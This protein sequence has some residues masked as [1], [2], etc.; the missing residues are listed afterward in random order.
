MIDVGITATLRPEILEQTLVSFR[1]NL[2]SSVDP[3]KVRFII[4]ID[5]VGLDVS[6]DEMVD[7]IREVLK[8]YSTFCLLPERASFSQAFYQLWLYGLGDPIRYPYYF[9][10]ED[11]WQL[12]YRIDLHYLIEIMEVNSRLASLRLPMF[13]SNETMKNWNL[14]FPWNGTYYECPE[15]LKAAVGFCGHP[16]LIRKTFMKNLFPYLDKD[17]NPEKQFH[18]KGG[19]FEKEA[20]EW[21]Y[22]VFGRP[23]MG[24]YIK[25]LGRQ[26]MVDNNF[27]KKGT[28]AFFTHW[29]KKEASD[30]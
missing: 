17:K 29:T 22:G 24:P 1:D 2:F 3:N 26:W 30:E 11:D 9:N 25:D 27:R 8:G 7:M 21:E 20:V 18:Q 14:H 15:N 10:L 23:G 6:Q 5:P 28:K 19:V 16:S 13:H 12:L 4:N